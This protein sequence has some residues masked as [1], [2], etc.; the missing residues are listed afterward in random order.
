MS[1]RAS[2]AFT[3]VELLVVIGVIALLISMLL[4][5]LNAARESANR[6]K[7]A[8]NLRQIGLMTIMYASE[9]R[10]MAP[11]TFHQ[12]DA[13]PWMLYMAY[14]DQYIDANGK[15][16]PLSPE[17]VLFDGGYLKSPEVF[18]CPTQGVD[19]LRREYYP[20][21]WGTIPAGDKRVRTGYATRPYVEA[22]N[23][24]RDY[25]RLQKMPL[26]A[27]LSMDAANAAS[28]AS[29]R[30][31][32]NPAWNVMYRDGSVHLRVNRAVLDRMLST[33]GG[34]GLDWTQFG[35]VRD[36]LAE[37]PGATLY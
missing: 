32:G 34:G 4:P 2:R 12:I 10:G 9:H 1:N 7:C 33:A 22:K 18:Y 31:K 36:V 14:E 24:T 19:Y 37:V 8:N 6:V 11:E 16:R 15:L 27:V 13:L 35:R 3:L 30:S 17:A 25:D 29:H 28:Q 20:D 5:S 26:T 23:K 21:P